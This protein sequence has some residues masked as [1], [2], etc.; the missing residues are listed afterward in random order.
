MFG[1]SVRVKLVMKKTV[2]STCLFNQV[3]GLLWS[4]EYNELVSALSSQTPDRNDLVVWN[5][6]KFEFEAVAKLRQHMARPLHIALSPDETTIGTAQYTFKPC[7][8]CI[9]AVWSGSMLF[10]ISFSTRNR[11]GKRTTWILIG[12]LGCAGW[13]G[14]MLVANA[15]CWFCR[16]AAHL[17]QLILLGQ[18]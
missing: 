12:L 6:K 18:F 15:V 16:D 4:E 5:M 13:S 10:A 17:L 3:C 7:H 1:K 14:S 8:Y 11:V 9:R 2:I